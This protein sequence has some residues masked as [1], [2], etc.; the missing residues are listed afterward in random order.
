MSRQ[1]ID[2]TGKTYGRY[3]VLHR[4]AVNDS[5]GCARWVCKCA[6]G[7]EKIVSGAV[8]R[9]GST[10]SCGCYARERSTKHGAAGKVVNRH[11][12]GRVVGRDP[13]YSVWAT[14]VQRCTN[15]KDRGYKNYGGRGITVCDRWKNSFAAFKTDM[16]PRPEGLMIE[17][18]DNDS[19]YA[20]YNCYWADRTT[21]NNNT[22]RNKKVVAA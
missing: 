10:V 18:R 3:L 15:P 13:V 7:S 6:C 4:H 21:Q 19:G 22:R 8:L 12:K 16:G 5:M 20:P 9:N 1:A 11:A 17:R 14:M 2:M